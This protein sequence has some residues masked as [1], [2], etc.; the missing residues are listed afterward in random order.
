M[1]DHI[2][3][4][5]TQAKLNILKLEDLHDTHDCMAKQY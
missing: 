4:T 3:H 5:N 1:G 2:S